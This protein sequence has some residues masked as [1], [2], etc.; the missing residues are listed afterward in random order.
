MILTLHKNLESAQKGQIEC[1]NDPIEI[2]TVRYKMKSLYKDESIKNTLIGFAIPLIILSCFIII[3]GL[4]IQYG[5]GYNQISI[6]PGLILLLFAI[7]II[8]T[9]KQENF[10][11]NTVLNEYDIKYTAIKDKLQ[12][13]VND[14]YQSVSNLP[15]EILNTL[16]QRFIDY[17]SLH[18]VVKTPIYSK[19]EALD[20]LKNQLSIPY[21]NSISVTEL[22]KY[23]KF[24]TD[25]SRTVKGVD[26]DGN[27]ADIPVYLTDI[28]YLVR[29]SDTPD[30]LFK[31]DLAGTN[32]YNPYET[33][34]SSLKVHINVIIVWTILLSY[35]LFHLIYRNY[36]SESRFVQLFILLMILFIIIILIRV[37]ISDFY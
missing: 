3:I 21:D 8:A 17:N 11:E 28:D 24:N 12:S 27:V 7:S 22:M 16:I 31:N 19:Y 9:F 33:L 32:T 5:K 13:I 23:L 2:E 34:K 1:L 29:Y 30:L 6:L 36:G 14:N 18:Q 26:A 4:Y 10:T 37:Y 20:I 35:L 25:T 15:E